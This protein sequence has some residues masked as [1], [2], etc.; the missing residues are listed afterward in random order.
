MLY[1]VLRNREPMKNMIPNILDN[2]LKFENMPLEKMSMDARKEEMKMLRS[3]MLMYGYTIK[4]SDGEIGNVY[5]FLFDESTW[6]VKYMVVKNRA[7]DPGTKGS[8]LAR[9][10][11]P[12]GLALPKR[13]GV[14]DKR[15]GEK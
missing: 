7:M 9:R 13:Y 3:L 2:Y 8:Y 10:N 14:V 15:T 11:R 4:A 1:L 5:D 6:A 12:D